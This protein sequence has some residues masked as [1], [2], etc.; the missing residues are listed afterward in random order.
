LWDRGAA[1]QCCFRQEWIDL[2]IAT[3]KGSVDVDSP[4]DPAGLSAMVLQIKFK[5]DGDTKAGNVLHPVGIP[6][7][8]L[9]PLPYL[10]VLLKLGSDSIAVC[11]YICTCQIC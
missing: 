2:F 5:I 10:A 7:D 4:F 6:R 1:V 9:H 3:Y 8:P 11:I